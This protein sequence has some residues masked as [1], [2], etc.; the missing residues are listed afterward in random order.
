MSFDTPTSTCARCGK[1]IFFGIS[2]QA[3]LL[4][5]LVTND[6][7]P[8]DFATCQRLT[9]QYHLPTPDLDVIAA[10]IQKMMAE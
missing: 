5:A 4:D 3:W 6:P 1:P 7:M 8:P 2:S 9:G 10:G